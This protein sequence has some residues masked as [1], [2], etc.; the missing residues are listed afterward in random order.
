MLPFIDVNPVLLDCGVVDRALVLSHRGTPVGSDGLKIKLFE[1]PD[2]RLVINDFE[3]DGVRHRVNAFTRASDASLTPWERTSEG[4][5][6]SVLRPASGPEVAIDVLV[7]ATTYAPSGAVTAREV[8]AFEQQ[9]LYTPAAVKVRLP[10]PEDS[11][12]GG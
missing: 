10:S 6:L 4:A 9:S 3:H 7:V 11:R 5:R 12:P 1:L 8:A 2:T